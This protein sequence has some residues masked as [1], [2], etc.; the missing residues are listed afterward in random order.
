M[1]HN[2][3]FMSVFIAYGRFKN[4]VK[5]S[6]RMRKYDEKREKKKHLTLECASANHCVVQLAVK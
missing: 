2:R 1:V 5:Y 4:S 6:L 3:V